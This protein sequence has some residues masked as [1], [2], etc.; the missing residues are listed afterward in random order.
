MHLHKPFHAANL[1][2][3]SV[4]L[5]TG[6]VIRDVTKQSFL[7][8]QWHGNSQCLSLLDVMRDVSHANHSRITSLFIGR[9]FSFA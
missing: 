3:L 4:T 9:E 8:Y 1:K 7:V 6:S 2:F 5:M